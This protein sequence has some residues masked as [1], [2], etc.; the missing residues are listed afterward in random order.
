MSYIQVEIGGKLRGLKFNQYAHILIQEKIDPDH[1]TASINAALFYGGLKG[2]CFVKGEEPD[3]TFEDVNDWIEELPEDVIM[4][5][6]NIY[7]NT[8]AFLRAK[9]LQ[10]SS[11]EDKKKES[12]DVS[13]DQSATDSP[14]VD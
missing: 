8:T 1:A 14:V 12:Q 2:N 10:E 11:E 4:S 5:V 3:F 13:I 6:Y 7:M 9:A